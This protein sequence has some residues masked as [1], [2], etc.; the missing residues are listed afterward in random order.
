MAESYQATKANNPEVLNDLDIYF[1]VADFSVNQNSFYQLGL[2]TVPKIMHFRPALA[3]SGGGRYATEP[4]QHMHM[5]G[6]I[7][8][9]SMSRFVKERTGVSIPIVRP[10]PPVTIILCVLLVLVILSIKP[11]LSNFGTLLRTVRNKYL[12]LAVSLMVYTFGISGGVYDI[13]RNPAPFMMKPDGTF[14]WFHPQPSVQFVVE[15]FI[16]GGLTLMCGMLAI[17]LV[18]VAPKLRSHIAQ[19]IAV[20]AFGMGF[21]MLFVNVMSLYKS[22]NNWY[23]PVF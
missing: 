11:V 17:L 3:E 12:W 15:G 9:E 13:I 7:M 2:Q 10:E 4:S 1:F 19:K 14:L 16:T 20:A 18:Q 6:Q 22:K 23:R 8:A 21:L 5:A